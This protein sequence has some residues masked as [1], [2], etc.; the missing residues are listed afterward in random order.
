AIA[1]PLGPALIAA[2]RAIMPTFS[3]GTTAET[4]AAVAGAPERHSAT[5]WLG[6]AALLVLLPG[7]L[8]VA[9]LTSDLAPR[10][11]W[12]AVALLVPGYMMLAFLVAGDG[13]TW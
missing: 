12:W 11:T 3:A 4:V 1:M 7:V 5:V 6:M 2:L 13:E 8:A 9:R 10:L